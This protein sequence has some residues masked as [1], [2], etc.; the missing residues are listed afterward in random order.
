MLKD[1]PWRKTESQ[2][3]KLYLSSLEYDENQYKGN[4]Y[5]WHHDDYMSF[6]FANVSYMYNYENAEHNG[7]Y[8]I[9]DYDY[10]TKIDFV[11]EDPTREGYIFDG[12]YREPECI[13][14][15]DFAIDTLPEEVTEEDEDGETVVT[16]QETRLYA[17]W[18]EK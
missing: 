4:L 17:K 8:W 12:W 3:T 5:K 15:W 16:Y 7:Y 14:K 11:P 2:T 1:T 13:R 18:T 6:Y 10:G 9:D